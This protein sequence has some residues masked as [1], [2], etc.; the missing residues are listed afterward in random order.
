MG[1]LFLSI[2][3][4]N[5]KENSRKCSNLGPLGCKGGFNHLISIFCDRQ[6]KEVPLSK[7]EKTFDNLG[8]P[9]LSNMN[10]TIL[11]TIYNEWHVEHNFVEHLLSLSIYCSH[12][13]AMST[14]D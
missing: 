7:S 3:F 12:K 13:L 14:N 8:S 6:I 4:M 9:Q 11:H 5:E 2:L 1:N 10:H